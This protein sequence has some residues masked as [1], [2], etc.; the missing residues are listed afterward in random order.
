MYQLVKA[1]ETSHNV[2]IESF[3]VD[4]E[5]SLKNKYGLLIPVLTDE[6]ENEIC[7]YFFDKLTFEQY[8]SN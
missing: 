3:N 6:D 5:Q 2:V 7:H 8:L 1:Y 4:Q